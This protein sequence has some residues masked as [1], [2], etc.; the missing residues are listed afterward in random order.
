M[1]IDRIK[2]LH[3]TNLTHPQVTL[4]RRL[5]L[6]KD[7]HFPIVFWFGELPLV[8]STAQEE[9]MQLQVDCITGSYAIWHVYATAFE[10]AYLLVD[11]SRDPG[12]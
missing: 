5:L 7:T 4:I 12:C 8:E 3:K 6:L 11:Q 9:D 2:Q 10:R 1:Q